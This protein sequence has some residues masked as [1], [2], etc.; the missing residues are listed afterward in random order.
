[1]LFRSEKLVRKICE[2]KSISFYGLRPQ[3]KKSSEASLRNIRR[4]FLKAIKTENHFDY[5]ALGHHAQDQLETVL[6]R[7]V[8]GTG[9]F[10]LEG[11]K[12]KNG[13]LLRPLL[14]FTAGEISNYVAT[15]Q[16]K[17]RIDH[18]NFS[19]QYFRNQIRLELIPVLEKLSHRYGGT[20]AFYR[21]IHSLFSEVGDLKTLQERQIRRVYNELSFSTPFWI[22]INLEKF[23]KLSLLNKRQFI[24]LICRDLKI[25]S[26]RK[27]ID[28]I[29]E[30]ILA[31]KNMDGVGG[32]KISISCGEIFFQGKN[33]RVRQGKILH[34]LQLEIPLPKVPEGYE[35]RFARAGDRFRS[36]KLKKKQ[37]GRASCRE[38]VSSP[39]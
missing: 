34:P 5:I 30:K 26:G 4:R 31:Q 33:H 12:A 37:I 3:V 22:R 24:H 8:R 35:L 28:F 13:S 21:R 16:L 6:M 11:M 36:G 32:L 15:H 39:V 27:E 18:S 7:I 17:F 29:L 10:G 9:V 20:E 14:P 1:M 2:A 38:R 25:E 19:E 23:K